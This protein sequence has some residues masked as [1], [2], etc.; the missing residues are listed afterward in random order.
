MFESILFLFGFVVGTAITYF[1][2]TKVNNMMKKLEILHKD[3][4]ICI[5]K[6]HKML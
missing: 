6:W 4:E 2:Y 3:I 1:Y 5:M